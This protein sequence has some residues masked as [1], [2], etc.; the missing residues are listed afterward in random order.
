MEERV[1]LGKVKDSFQNH[2]IHNEHIFLTRHEWQCGWYWAFGYIGNSHIDTHFENTLLHKNEIKGIFV[3][4]LYTQNDWCI[5]QE[6]FARA[7]SLKKAADI[8]HYGNAGIAASLQCGPSIKRPEIEVIINNDLEGVL[9][10]L[11]KF[12]IENQIK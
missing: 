7:Y 1:Y 8:Y 11:W 6:L 5:I 2:I 4:P 10:T 3:T 9:D 12:V